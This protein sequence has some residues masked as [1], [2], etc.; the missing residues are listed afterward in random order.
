MW[1]FRG[2]ASAHWDVTMT[3][4]RMAVFL[5]GDV[6]SLDQAIPVQ[7]L[8]PRTAG[9]ADST[10]AG[11]PMVGCPGGVHLFGASPNSR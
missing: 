2:L 6:L 7:V 8:A 4:H 10:L 1:Q 9:L 5:L 11:R 3:R